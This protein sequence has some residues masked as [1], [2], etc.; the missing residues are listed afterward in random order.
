MKKFAV[1]K[2]MKKFWKV[3]GEKVWEIPPTLLE[4]NVKYPIITG[5]GTLTPKVPIGPNAV[6]NI[7]II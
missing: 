4:K 6:E 7:C 2:R 5:E 3:C 1:K